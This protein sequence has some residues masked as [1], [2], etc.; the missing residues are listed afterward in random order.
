MK[1]GNSIQQFL[2]KCL[3][4]LRKDFSELRAA[5]DVII[6]FFM[7]RPCLVAQIRVYFSATRDY[8]CSSVF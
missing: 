7:K 3:D 5:G 8:V 2:I 6:L 4:Q 1:K